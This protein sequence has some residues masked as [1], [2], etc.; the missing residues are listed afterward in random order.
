MTKSSRQAKKLS[1]NDA[2]PPKCVFVDEGPSGIGKP[3][4]GTTRID[5]GHYAIEI[6][7][8]HMDPY[9]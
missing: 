9:F 1:H 6:I 2:I 4:N 8:V 7:W 5:T 3:M